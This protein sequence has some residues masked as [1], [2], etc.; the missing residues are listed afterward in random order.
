MFELRGANGH[1]NEP[2]IS[3]THK[4]ITVAWVFLDCNTYKCL[5]FERNTDGF[6]L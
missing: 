4:V 5:Q 2:Y 1:L 6:P 3:E